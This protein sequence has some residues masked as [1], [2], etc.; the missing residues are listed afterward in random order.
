MG[1]YKYTEYLADNLFNGYSKKWVPTNTQ[2]TS[3]ITCSMA[4]PGNQPEEYG[5]QWLFQHEVGW[6]IFAVSNHTHQGEHDHKHHHFPKT[7][8]KIETTVIIITSVYNAPY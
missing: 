2:S 5:V 4:G 8:H 1:A 6:E 3:L 7:W